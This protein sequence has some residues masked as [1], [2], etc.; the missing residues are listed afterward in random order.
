MTDYECVKYD[1]GK[2]SDTKSTCSELLNVHTNA[3]STSAVSNNWAVIISGGVF[4]T[5]I[6]NAIGMTA[7]RYTSALDNSMAIDE[8][9]F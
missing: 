5:L 7:L 2:S 9:G 4:H 3:M 6:K 1:L 8:I